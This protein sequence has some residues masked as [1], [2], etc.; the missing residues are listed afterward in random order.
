MWLFHNLNWR[1][2]LLFVMP[3]NTFRIRAITDLK[4]VLFCLNMQNLLC[5]WMLIFRSCSKWCLYFPVISY[6]FCRFLPD[7]ENHLPINTEER[8]KG[9][10]K[11][12]SEPSGKCVV[13]F[14]EYNWLYFTKNLYWEK[15][16]LAVLYTVVNGQMYSS[17]VCKWVKCVS[18]HLDWRN[19][20]PWTKLQPFCTYTLPGNIPHTVHTSCQPTLQHHNSYNNADNY[21]QWNAVGSPDDGHKDARYMLKYYWIPINHSWLHLVGL[22][23][24]YLE[25]SF[26]KIIFLSPNFTSPIHNVT[27]I[28]FFHIN[29]FLCR[30]YPEVSLKH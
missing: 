16:N 10:G 12:L 1:S 9:E 5:C 24:T 29:I 27:D 20:A 13:M 2:A 8:K 30:A 18:C 17:C 25:F 3:L 23:L 4:F 28:H 26:K 14:C 21:R 6:V 7:T 11:Q 15:F 19:L 22:S